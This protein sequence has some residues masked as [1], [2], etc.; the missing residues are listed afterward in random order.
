VK[1][2]ARLDSGEAA[3]RRIV[4]RFSLLSRA[5]DGRKRRRERERERESEREREREEYMDPLRRLVRKLT[6]DYLI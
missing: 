5:R 6:N 3:D 4:L 1:L 2:L